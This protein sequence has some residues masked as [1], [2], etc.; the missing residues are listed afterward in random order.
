MISDAHVAIYDSCNETI[1]TFARNKVQFILYS[2]CRKGIPK[3]LLRFYPFVSIP[4][5]LLSLTLSNNSG[6]YSDLASEGLPNTSYNAHYPS[7]GPKNYIHSE[8]PL[9]LI[10]LASITKQFYLHSLSCIDSDAI[11]FRVDGETLTCIGPQMNVSV[12]IN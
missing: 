2:K 3:N 1:L 5:L 6:P 7:E 12:K 8:Q 11:G 9:T 4:S 10:R